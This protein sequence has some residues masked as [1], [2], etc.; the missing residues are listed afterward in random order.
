MKSGNGGTLDIELCRYTLNNPKDVF[1]NL[2]VCI[3]QFLERALPVYLKNLLPVQ[4]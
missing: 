4:S 2:T 1:E 3:E